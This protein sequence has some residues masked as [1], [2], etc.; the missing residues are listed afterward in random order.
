[1]NKVF[2]YP[3]SYLRDR[4]LDVIRNWC[5]DEV[6]NPQ[7]AKDREGA[8]VTKKKALSKTRSNSWKKKLPLPN[9]KIRP[10]E[11]PKNSVVYVWGGM[12]AS[13]KFI[14]DIDNPYTLFG[15]RISLTL[16][17]WLIK[18][19]LLS[20][21]CLEIRCMSQACLET[22]KILFGKDVYNKAYVLYPSVGISKRKRKVE[23]RNNCNFFMVGTQ[24]DIK[25]GQALVN[26]FE[27]LVLENSNVTLTIVSNISEID[28]KRL[29]NIQNIR[30]IEPNLSREQIIVLLQNQAD[31]LVHP[32]YA[33]SFAMVILEALSCQLPI[34]ATDV[35]AIREMVHDGVNGYLLQPPVSVWDG[36]FRSKDFSKIRELA[37]KIDT[38]S[39]EEKLLNAMRRLASDVPLRQQFSKQ[40]ENLFDEVFKAKVV[41]KAVDL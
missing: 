18:S 34:I 1:M 33:D 16:W 20:R 5:A 3:H 41:S 40:S 30:I 8:Q 6:V 31:V 26:S 28:K 13:K 14:V 2:F 23:N 35:Y 11:A 19:I 38:K 27:R 36:P 25:G 24:F 39:F 4:Q 29:N 10:A 32:T 15:S 21:R 7:I 22:T 37:S 12:I 9:I 17:G